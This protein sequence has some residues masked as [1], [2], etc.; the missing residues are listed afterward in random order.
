MPSYLNKLAVVKQI[1]LFAQLNFFEL[2]RI[3]RRATFVDYKKGDLICKQGAPADAFYCLVSGRV[4]CYTIDQFSHK[5]AVEFIHRGRHFGILSALTGE[6]HSHNFEAINDSV[7]LKINRDDFSDILK[8][9]P[10]LGVALSQSLSHRIRNQVVHDDTKVES[11]ILSVYSPVKGSGSSTYAI[12]LALNLQKETDKKVLLISLTSSKEEH[13]PASEINEATPQWKSAGIDLQSIADDPQKISKSIVRGELNIDFLNAAFDPDDRTLVTKISRFVSAPVDDYNYIIVDLPNEM[14]DMVLKTLTQS[15]HVHLVV[16]DRDKDLETTRQVIDRLQENLGGSFS[17]EKVSVILSGV[18]SEE[19]RP[20]EKIKEFLNYDVFAILPHIAAAQLNAAVVSKGLTVITPDP[21]SHYAKTIVRI[22]RKTSGVLVGLVLGGGAALGVAH[23]GVIRVLERENIPVDIVI[24]SS[25]GALIGSMWAIGKNA[26]ELEFIAR[27]F[28]NKS[29]LLKLFDPPAFPISG[30]IRGRKIALWLKSKLGNSTFYNTRIPFRAVAYDLLLREEL[31][32]D[33]GSLV[34]A[35][36]K[37]I[38]IPGVIR[39]R[40]ENGQMIIDGGVLNPLPTNVLANMGIKKIIAVNVLQSPSHVAQ[41][42][43]MELKQ[44]ELTSKVKFFQ[45]PMRYLGFRVGRFFTNLFI[46]NISD[47]I[48]RTLQASEYIIAEQSCRQAN[49]VIHPNLVGIN[50]FELYKVDELI[51]LGEEA[52][53][54]NLPAI[55]E[56][57]KE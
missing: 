45:D 19:M 57:I 35:V 6:N 29:S 24:G 4:S 28:K 8:A 51:R 30:L 53:I 39:P 1:P 47:I 15:D 50:W 37:S 41:G 42:H 46:P 7:V 31:V 34:D 56:L 44:L 11:T 52:T 3:A 48:V 22:A 13:K 26:D 17:L 5:S 23:V 40:M 27:E 10:R 38:A 12:N 9:T 32:I 2:N 18:L 21:T 55:K 54:Q 33:Q 25:M 20:V 43:Q 36:C 49:V 16:A 14:D